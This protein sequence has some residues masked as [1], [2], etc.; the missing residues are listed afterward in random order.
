MSWHN[1]GIVVSLTKGMNSIIDED[2]YERINKWSWCS[3]SDGYAKRKRCVDGKQTTILMHR[4][5][6][7]APAG[8]QV[9]HIN[10]NKL[11]NRKSNLRFCDNK[12]NSA[13][14]KKRK[15][16]SS[17]YKGVYYAKKDKKWI[18]NICIDGKSINLGRFDSAQDAAIKYNSCAKVAFGE[19]ARINRL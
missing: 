8:T 3:T 17:G 4:F 12:Q 2:D 16:N 18:A 6:L 1:H 15:D 13:N 11:D 10:G 7:N 14:S 9:D 19:F 5:I